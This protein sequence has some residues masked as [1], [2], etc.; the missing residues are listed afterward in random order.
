MEEVISPPPKGKEGEPPSREVPLF[1]PSNSSTFSHLPQ[2]PQGIPSAGSFRQ[3]SSIPMYPVVNE[4]IAQ[5]G[6]D[7]PSGSVKAKEDE[8]QKTRNDILEYERIMNLQA[9]Q[10]RSDLSYA[11]II[12][13]ILLVSIAGKPGLISLSFGGAATYL[14]DLLESVEV[15][16][17]GILR[18]FICITVTDIGLLLYL[19]RREV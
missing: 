13:A 15:N 19:L 4:T 18:L 2:P 8:E 14:L 9:S 6:R 16:Y 3:P 10:I 1:P 17:I 12:P 7:K 5:P 11:C